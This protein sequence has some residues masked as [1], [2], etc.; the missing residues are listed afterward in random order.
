MRL[1]SSSSVFV[2][3]A[4]ACVALTAC[5]DDPATDGGGGGGA[6]AEAA[7]FIGELC[8]LYE[9]CCAIGKSSKNDCIAAV[10]GVATDQAFDAARAALCLRAI[11]A[12][13]QK[14][15]FCTQAPDSVT[16]AAVFK[17]PR[18]LPVGSS[19]ARS[20]DCANPPENEGDALCESGRCRILTR[21]KA[22]DACFGTRAAG[23][24]DELVKP[25]DGP[26]A[27]CAISEGL[28]CSAK[29][30]NCTARADVGVACEGSDVSCVDG[31]WCP[32]T[33]S[34][35]VERTDAGTP[36]EDTYEC[37]SGSQCSNDDEGGAA[38]TA[39]VA[40]GGRCERGDECD[41]A[42]VCDSSSRCIRDPEEYAGSC[43]GKLVFDEPL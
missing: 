16:C 21:G 14:P 25:A 39:F 20:S 1:A 8:A 40:E 33:S 28:Y 6:P 26:L 35:C 11:R 38:C 24:T 19:C 41:P 43:A 9:P 42:L 3:V 27:L 29:T 13:A 37:A 18:A 34:L 17:H 32:T 30:G 12:E 5:G 4:L 36:C 22:G 23:G 31:A 7:A 2:S 15:S 10:N